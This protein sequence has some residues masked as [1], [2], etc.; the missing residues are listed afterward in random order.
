M[1]DQIYPQIFQ[2]DPTLRIMIY[3]G[4]ADACVPFFG[5]KNW[6]Q[7]IGGAVKDPWRPWQYGDANDQQLAGYTVGYERLR[8]T[9]LKG[10]GHM[11]PEFGPAQSFQMF[12]NYLADSFPSAPAA[13]RSV[14]NWKQ[15][16]MAE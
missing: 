6:T 1:P 9:S 10:I 12:K 7:T 13:A 8:F 14:P 2:L 16:P 11:A 15:R 3:S 5:T 4:D